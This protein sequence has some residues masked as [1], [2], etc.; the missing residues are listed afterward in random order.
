MKY[1]SLIFFIVLNLYAAQLKSITDISGEVVEIPAQINSIA[2]LWDANNQVIFIL[3]GEAKIVTT[4]DVVKQNPWFVQ[5]YPH[6]K[7][8]PA[9]WNKNSIQIEEI[10]KLNPDV[11]I[12]PNKG[13]ADTI[14]K[15]GLKVIRPVFSSYDGF[16]QSVRITADI[17]GDDA[18]KRAEEFITYFDAN[19]KRVT[20]RMSKFKENERV[21]VL[22]IVSGAN[23]TRVD[24]SKTIMDEWIR[25]A[26]GK[27]V[28]EKTGNLLNITLEEIMAADP[29][30]IIIGSEKSEYW[31]NKFYENP[32]LSGL[33]AVKNR[34][35]YANPMGV[36]KWDRHGAEGALQILWAGKILHP[37]LF[38]DIDM[39][40]ET[41]AFY[42]RFFRYDLSDA[43][44]EYM[45]K[46]LSPSGE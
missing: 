41:K 8:I 35:V 4:T 21:R 46:G 36:F 16:K 45:S 24:G 28:I 26:G 2:A 7:D 44:F 30:V 1:L 32:T 42:K 37:E 5:I 27:N 40:A 34:R 17:I 23:I 6:I 33:K 29:D 19:V 11:V 13:F 22:H 15:Q 9:T 39:R 25:A 38:T 12:I 14:R 43:E 10:I 31:V 3:G 18:P 20:D